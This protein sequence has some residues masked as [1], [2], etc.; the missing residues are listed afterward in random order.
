MAIVFF[1]EY[2]SLVPAKCYLLEKGIDGLGPFLPVLDEIVQ[3]GT[4]FFVA[5]SLLNLLQVSPRPEHLPLVITAGRVWFAA[6]P[7]DKAFWVGHGVGRRL[8]S[9]IETIMRLDPKVFARNQADR[10]EIERL[11]ANLVRLGIS[12]AHLLEEAIRLS[13]DDPA[14]DA[15]ERRR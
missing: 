8:C 2:V 14:V 6:H 15:T 3:K 4:F 11:L 5:L 1:N 12:D 13:N 10:L 7:D 9:I